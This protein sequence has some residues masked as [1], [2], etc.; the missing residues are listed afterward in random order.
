M[1]CSPN[2]RAH[3]PKSESKNAIN[4]QKKHAPYLLHLI[5]NVPHDSYS[6]NWSAF[7]NFLRIHMIRWFL[8]S[9]NLGMNHY[10][11]F[12]SIAW[13]DLFDTISQKKILSKVFFL[14]DNN[15]CTNFH[16]FLSFFL[17][18]PILSFDPFKSYREKNKIK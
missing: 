17:F 6:F 1:K 9:I 8:P 12:D 10:F 14:F 4:V 16:Y 15:F 7:R 2:D 5:Q 11:D 3:F 18:L 13:L